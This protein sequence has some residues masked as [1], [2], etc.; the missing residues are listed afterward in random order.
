MSKKR[1]PLKINAMVIFADLFLNSYKK[2]KIY[3]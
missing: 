3:Y 2:K 1:Q